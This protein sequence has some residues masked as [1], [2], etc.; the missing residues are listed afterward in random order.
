MVIAKAIANG[1]PLGAVAARSEIMKSWGPVSHGTTC[2]GNPVSCAAA[3]AVID[4]IREEKLLDN[5][6]R[7]GTYILEQ[8]RELK[9]KSK[10]I[11]DVRGLG[12]MIAVEFI[13]HGTD[14]VPNTEVV[15]RILQIAL[16]NGLLLYP[17]GH[18]NQVIRLIPALTVNR[19]QIKEG[20]K[21]F[22]EAVL[23]AEGNW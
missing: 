14:K 5:A 19:D 11:G 17:C 7:Q 13:K 20:L 21:I 9:T 6:K 8:L 1:F 23:E 3:L 22:S 16:N 18:W 12:L 2:G 15:K 4:I 10:I